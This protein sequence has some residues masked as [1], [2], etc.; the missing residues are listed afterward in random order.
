M[1]SA[2][3]H[4]ATMNRLIQRLSRLPGLGKR[5]A[6]RLAYHLLKQPDEEALELAAAIT[7]LKRNVRPCAR[8]FNLA[9]AEVC[10]ICADP[11][12]DQATVLVVEQPGD[13]VSLETT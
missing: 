7:D 9:E 8:C 10:T 6:E 3:S 11:R 5:S 2:S 1:S 4:T 12:R 13:V